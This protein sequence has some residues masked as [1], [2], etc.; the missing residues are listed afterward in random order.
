MDCFHV[1]PLL[2]E[3]QIPPPLPLQARA[4]VPSI[5]NDT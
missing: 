5:K 4:L 2:R 1:A 3:Y